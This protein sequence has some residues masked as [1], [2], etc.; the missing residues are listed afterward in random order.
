H[1]L[2]QIHV[3]ELEAEGDLGGR[4]ALERMVAE[5][6]AG[7]VEQTLQPQAGERRPRL[8]RVDLSSPDEPVALVSL[9][10]GG[11]EVT[12]RARGELGSGQLGVIAA[13]T[14]QAVG[15]LVTG[16]GFTPVEVGEVHLFGRDAVVALVVEE[17]GPEM[18]GAVLVRHGS[19]SEAAVRA[20]LDAVNRR[21]QRQG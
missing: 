18:L 14:L 10:E 21:L 7:A 6:E 2:R 13:A 4:D 16:P 19:V 5:M 1:A 17:G 20:T 15:R 3:F 12:G 8:S 11:N 9:R